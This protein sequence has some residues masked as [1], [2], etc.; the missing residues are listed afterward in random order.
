MWLQRDKEPVC[1]Q[2]ATIR[3]AV[4]RST[5]TNGCISDNIH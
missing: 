4:A 2:V 3:T 1:H 5:T